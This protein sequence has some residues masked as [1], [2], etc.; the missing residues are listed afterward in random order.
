METSKTKHTVDVG[1]YV[2]LGGLFIQI[3]AFGMF[4]IVTLV[5]LIRVRK[6][7]TPISSSPSL[8]WKKHL[9]VLIA[10]SCLI[11]VRSI[12]RVVEYAQGNSGFILSH[13]VFLYI[14]DGSLVFVCLAI[15][16]L[17]HPSELIKRGLKGTIESEEMGEVALGN[18]PKK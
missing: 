6:D 17:V 9:Y 8:S 1:Q 16:N 13:E 15:F 10:A 14:F 2:I 18:V 7:P 11:M 5:F 3:L 4:M 12:V